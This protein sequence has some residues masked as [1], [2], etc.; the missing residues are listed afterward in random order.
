MSLDASCHRA[1]ARGAVAFIALALGLS[2]HATA[3][4]SPLPVVAGDFPCLTKLTPVRGFYVGNLRG[5]LAATL[6]VARSPNGGVYPPG[7]VVQLIPTEVMVKQPVGT[8]PVTRDWEFFELAVSSAGSRIVKRGYADLVASDGGSCFGCHAAARPEWDMI[9]ES[10]HGCAPIPETP[11]MI[12]ALQHTD[13]RCKGSDKVSAQD[14]Q[15]LRELAIVERKAA[16]A[17]R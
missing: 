8:S 16:A 7:S 2:L 13:P 17:K 3:A 15:A 4:P 11:P 1:C 12:R 9:C 10:T 5:D 14:A 6:R